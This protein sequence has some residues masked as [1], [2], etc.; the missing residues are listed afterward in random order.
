MS[1]RRLLLSLNDGIIADGQWHE[2]TDMC[3]I[4]GSSKSG[5]ISSP[6]LSIRQRY[7][8]D[9]CSGDTFVIKK[10]DIQFDAKDFMVDEKSNM[11]WKYKW[12]A[13]SRYDFRYCMYT[14]KDGTDIVE[15]TTM[16]GQSISSTEYSGLHKED[17]EMIYDDSY[18]SASGQNYFL[19]MYLDYTAHNTYD[20]KDKF[21]YKLPT[22]YNKT[23]NLINIPYYQT[24]YSA[25][26]PKAVHV[27]YF[28]NGD[29][30]QKATFYPLDCGDL[31]DYHIVL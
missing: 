12:S 29:T 10:E 4:K 22:I 7:H 20:E 13:S 23:K 18:T 19:A 9:G 8:F 2:L 3:H 26:Y 25:Y 11:T 24:C 1:N 16:T 6:I 21:Y 5:S 27:L 17:I 15:K 28:L 14:F 31:G 30:N